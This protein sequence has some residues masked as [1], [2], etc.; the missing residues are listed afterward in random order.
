MADI[1]MTSQSITIGKIPLENI[2]GIEDK[3]QRERKRY[4]RMYKNIQ[5][6]M[7]KTR[8]GRKIV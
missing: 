7:R 2:D 4:D 1:I 8:Y 5:R 3:L 6:R